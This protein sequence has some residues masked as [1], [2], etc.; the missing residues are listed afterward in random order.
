MPLAIADVVGKAREELSKL[1]GLEISN[2]L[3]AAKNEG[4][5][6]VSIEAVEKHSLP[7]SM[8]ILGRYEVLLDEKGDLLEF[9]R[10]RMRKRVDVYDEEGETE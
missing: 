9:S 10:K 4:G 2:T 6:Q 3:G 7:D 5:W 8:D 1:T